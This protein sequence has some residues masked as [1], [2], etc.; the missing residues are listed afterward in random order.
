MFSHPD[1]VPLTVLDRRVKMEFSA[2]VH[3]EQREWYYKWDDTKSIDDLE[4]PES[5]PLLS[6][7][8]VADFAEFRFLDSVEGE[9][10]IC[11]PSGTVMRFDMRALRSRVET[12]ELS[13]TEL[14]GAAEK[15]TKAIPANL[16]WLYNFVLETPAQAIAEAKAKGA[17]FKDMGEVTGYDYFHQ[18]VPFFHERW[19]FT[20]SLAAMDFVRVLKEHCPES[21]PW[22]NLAEYEDVI[23]RL[24]P[25][26]GW[27]LCV[28][29]AFAAEEWSKR[30]LSP[31]WRQSAADRATST[32]RPPVRKEATAAAYKALYPTGHGSIPWLVVLR[33]VNKLSGLDASVFTLRRAVAM[34]QNSVV[35]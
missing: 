15:A 9:T 25:V 4:G 19:A 35:S 33:E 7:L 2:A 26:E 12:L 11:S 16:T 28:P 14:I 18:D 23:A 3:D 6:K 20:I 8:T 21:L 32:G 10:F 24:R 27:S 13:Y 22:V 30:L 31:R 29:E 17:A 1:Y 34:L 5:F